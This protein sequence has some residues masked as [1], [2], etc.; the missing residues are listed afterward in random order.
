MLEK[1]KSKIHIPEI[2]YPIQPPV[3]EPKRKKLIPSFISGLQD[4]AA[5]ENYSSIFSYFWPEFIS[6]LMLTSFLNICDALWIANLKST[7]TYATLNVTTNFI[8]F[9]IK[10]AEGLTIGSVVL[11]GQ[12]NGLTNYKTAGRVLRD[13]FWI[14]VLVGSLFAAILFFGAHHIYAMYGVPE[15]MIVLGTPYLRV[16]A[17]RVFFMFI[18]LSL[19]GFLRGIK[20]TKVPMQIFIIGG[21][22][23]LFFDYTLIH[24][25]FGFPALRL[26]GSALAS[27]IQ[28]AMMSLLTFAY[29]RFN[30]EIQRYEINFLQG[31]SSWHNIKHIILLSLP[32]ILDKAALA[33]SYIWLGSLITSMGKY[34]IASFGVIKEL[35]RLALIPAVAFAQ[36]ITF[37]VSN[38]YGIQDWHGI[39]SN[40][41]K[42]LFLASTMVLTVLALFSFNA[43][44][45]IPFFDHKT[46]FTEFSAGVLPYLSLLAFF[47][48]LQLILSGALR[49]ASNVKTVMTVRLGTIFGLFLPLSYLL[50]KLP[51]EDATLKFFLIYGSFYLTNAIM[52]VIYIYH[53]RGERWKGKMIG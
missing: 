3:E 29:L 8:H 47:D 1:E 53:L 40:I 34:A 35:E 30:N 44:L 22:I 5:G 33:A 51:V 38:A 2:P 10:V 14:N 46:K 31:I 23:F 27:V 48:V 19:I 17:I 4:F 26:Q 25:A 20:N 13:V 52:S 28:Y 18:Y 6:A 12:H 45:I 21:M 15:K 50:S 16:Q 37:L 42:I 32:T 24:G 43:H 11:C 36:V 41:K 7:S 9:M 49:G 39:K